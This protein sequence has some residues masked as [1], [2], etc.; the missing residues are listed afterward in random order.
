MR[1]HDHRGVG[2]HVNGT[3]GDL[4]EERRL[5]RALVDLVRRLDGDRAMGRVDR[6]DLGLDRRRDAGRVPADLLSVGGDCR[7]LIGNLVDS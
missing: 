2:R 6:R 7:G 1:Q 4:V 5:A 3:A